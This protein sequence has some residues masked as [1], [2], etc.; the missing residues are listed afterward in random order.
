[1]LEAIR[2]KYGT[3]ITRVSRG[4]AYEFSKRSGAFGV[5]YLVA[6][7]DDIEQRVYL[8]LLEKGYGIEHL[9]SKDA[10]QASL[11]LFAR[12]AGHREVETRHRRARSA[13]GGFLEVQSDLRGEYDKLPAVAGDP[14]AVALQEE[15]ETSL[16]D[17][18]RG[19]LDRLSGSA[20]AVMVP[21]V[22]EGL[23][24][25]EIAER[26]SLSYG[27]VRNLLSQSAKA[28]QGGEMASLHGVRGYFHP[29][30][31]KPR[32]TGA[33]PTALLALLS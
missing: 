27:Q 24:A 3:T 10:P 14:E 22:L 12:N 6:S 11:R 9:D 17:I 18:A 5:G 29:T 21:F 1:L 15:L 30:V 19:L 28:F 33:S 20:Y 32:T 16:T 4:V 2:A 8:K 23:D 31:K 7:A 26:T 25:R 13:D